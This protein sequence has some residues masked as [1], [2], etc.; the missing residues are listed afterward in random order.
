MWVGL[1]AADKLGSVVGAV[2]SVLGLG[3]SAYGLVRARNPESP[4]PA[5]AAAVTNSLADVTTAELVLQAGTIGGGVAAGDGNVVG[6]HNLVAGPGGVVAGPGAQVLL[7]ALVS[8]AEPLPPPAVDLCVGRDTQVAGVVAGWK[9][10]RSVVV[11]GGPGIG[12]STVLGRAVTDPAIVAAF[13]ARRFVVS[14]DGA[15]SAAAVVDKMALVLGVAPG[16]HLRNRVLAFVRE[17]PCVLIL[18][19]FETPADADPA[20]AVGLVAE[21]RAGAADSTVVGIG[22]RGGGAPVGLTGMAETV[23]GPLSPAAAAEVFSEVAGDRHRG[24]PMVTVLVAELDGVPLA[25]TLLATLARS[26]AGLDTL[27]AA[28]R[29]KRT[30]LLAH[31][32][33]PDR[34]SSLPVS[35]ELSWDRLSSD[36]RT[37]LSLAALLPDG[38]PRD[39]PGLYLPDEFAAGVIELG[40]RALVHSDHPRQRC[41]APIRRHVAAHHPPE[42]AALARLVARVQTLAELADRV[43]DEAG[44]EAVAT[45]VPEF[46]NIVD[47]IQARLPHD[48]APLAPLVRK[49]LLFQRFTGLGDDRLARETLSSDLEPL[50]RADIASA[51]GE[52]YTGRGENS[53]A[54][55]LFDQAL[56]LYRRAGSV[57]G[58]ANCLS[59]LGELEFIESDNARASE[60]YGQALPLYRRAGSVLGEANCLRNLGELEFNESDNVRAR[61]LFDKALPLY[62]RVGDVL[63]EANCLRNL[64]TLEFYESDNVRARELYGQALP[65]YQRVGD[66]LG[67]ANCLRNLGELEFYESDNVRARE[68]FDQALPLYQRVGSVLGEA[69]CLRNLGTLEFFESDNVR[70]RE[71]LDQAMTLYQRIGD[72]YSQELTYTWLARLP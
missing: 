31:A 8:P 57:L 70:A 26:E 49:L 33:R 62:Q 6:D 12:K 42:P 7:P 22:Y 65:L 27:M 56:P 35:I 41:L 21:V 15:E 23:L 50:T 20:G 17:A 48:P 52:L 58:E 71:L 54:R 59:N 19:N 37:V 55:K 14:C 30:D 29:A 28:W 11:A 10:G 61:E 53:R 2:C 38:W 44:S 40:R 13:G 4:A 24:D 1:E 36:A 60:L 46:T 72:R 25:I 66:V 18:D 32:A 34:T 69:N 5:G 43:G 51:L 45:V 64:G 39:R 47:V 63:G 67:E 3:L 68:L 16:E 9:A